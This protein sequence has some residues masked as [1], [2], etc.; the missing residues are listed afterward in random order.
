MSNPE[1]L[2]VDEN[3]LITT[4][5]EGNASVTVINSCFKITCINEKTIIGEVFLSDL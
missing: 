5:K 2:T 3:G 1:I 4:T